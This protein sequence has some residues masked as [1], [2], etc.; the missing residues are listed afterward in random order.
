MEVLGIDIGGTGIKGAI[1]DIET[2]ALKTERFKYA[3]PKG[4]N[5]DDVSAVVNTLIKDIGWKN[6]KPIGFGF[7][8]VIK[9]G[10][11]HTATNIS[12]N[13]IGVDLNEAFSKS[14]GNDQIYCLNDADA[15][16]IAEVTY[17]PEGVADG[18]TIFLTIG[19]GIGSAVFKNG[20]LLTNTELGLLKYKGDLLE[21]YAS[22]KVRKDLNLD[23]PEWTLRLNEVLQHIERVLSPELL[24]L[25]GGISKRMHLFEAYLDTT[26]PIKKSKYEN[27]AG[28]IGAASAAYKA[29]S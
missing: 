20:L 22:N 27:R 16:G 24:I 23:Y 2:G 21:R 15:A 1:V 17:N 7:P 13:W 18:T 14:T 4:G 10:V 12:K 29:F 11:C 5:I 19:T 26:C 6:D 25:G 8:S 9:N 28:I 3:T